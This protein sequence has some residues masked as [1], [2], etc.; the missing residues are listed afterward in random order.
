MAP[1]L[2]GDAD[3]RVRAE[4]GPR[5]PHG[6][7]PR[8]AR[9][10]LRV[11]RVLRG[12]G[13]QVLRQAVLSEASPRRRRTAFIQEPALATEPAPRRRARGSLAA[14][15]A[16]GFSLARDRSVGLRRNR[17]LPHLRISAQSAGPPTQRL[18]RHPRSSLTCAVPALHARASPRVV[19]SPRGSVF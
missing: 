2:R 10:R 17:L 11:R 9:A 1:G 8:A 16:G 18:S 7:H 6:R 19:T 5:L 14:A 13:L 3:P 4:P 15:S 12:G